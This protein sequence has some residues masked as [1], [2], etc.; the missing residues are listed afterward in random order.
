[1]LPKIDTQEAGAT[2][3]TPLAALTM[4]PAAMAGAE[5][6]AELPPAGVRVPPPARV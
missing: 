3:A 1:L 2:P 4:P 6:A 5:L